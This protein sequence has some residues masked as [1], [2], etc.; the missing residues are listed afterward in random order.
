MTTNELM[1][2]MKLKSPAA[3]EARLQYFKA[4][5]AKDASKQQP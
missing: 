5:Q 2:K 3:V 4:K 1:I